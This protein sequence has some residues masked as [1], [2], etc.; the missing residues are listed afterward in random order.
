MAMKQQSRATNST[1]HSQ[2]SPALSVACANLAFF[3]VSFLA[4]GNPL[5]LTLRLAPENARAQS[6]CLNQAATG[7]DRGAAPQAPERAALVALRDQRVQTESLSRL[8]ALQPTISRFDDVQRVYLDLIDALMVRS[9]F[10]WQVE[11]VHQVDPTSLSD[12]MNLISYVLS[13]ATRD[14]LQRAPWNLSGKAIDDINLA[15]FA[16]QRLTVH[17]REFLLTAH[18]LIRSRLLDLHKARQAHS[19]QQAGERRLGPKQTEG[20]RRI[21]AEVLGGL[22]AGATVGVFSGSTLESI[23]YS[24][25]AAYT[26]L[27]SSMAIGPMLTVLGMPEHRVRLQNKYQSMRTRWLER[28]YA[29]GLRTAISRL[30]A[31]NFESSGILKTPFDSDFSE[32]IQSQAQIQ[33]ES[34]LLSDFA[35]LQRRGLALSRAV[36]NLASIEMPDGR[37]FSQVTGP[38]DWTSERRQVFGHSLTRRLAQLEALR[39][40]AALLSTAVGEFLASD[41][42]IPQPNLAGHD[43]ALINGQLGTL[44]GLQESFRLIE[45]AA[46]EKTLQQEL[47]RRQ[48][49]ADL[50][51]F[52]RHGSGT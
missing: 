11:K 41:A 19:L 6:H 33:T 20:W 26:A 27:W 5:H 4:S 34:A 46:Y 16:F 21:R 43:V 10:F 51:D 3:V 24:T 2:V 49:E 31:P 13:S 38:A 7:V 18:D 1:S 36:G 50:L 15:L 45:R 14:Q 42:L 30:E 28:R 17:E 8:Q 25:S 47:L 22:V 35:L 32:W 12:R 44:T 37:R 52:S 48:L 9:N 40:E 39:S 23:G 29:R